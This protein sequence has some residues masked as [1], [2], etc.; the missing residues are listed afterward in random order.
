MGFCL[1]L[2][3]LTAKGRDKPIGLRLRQNYKLAEIWRELGKFKFSIQICSFD[4]CKIIMSFIILSSSCPRIPSSWLS[5]HQTVN[6]LLTM[7]RSSHQSASMED[8]SPSQIPLNMLVSSVAS[9]AMAP[10]FLLAS[11]PTGDQSFLSSPLTFQG[12]T[13]ATLQLVSELR[14]SI[15]LLSSSLA[16]LLSSS[17]PQMSLSSLVISSSTWSAS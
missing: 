10:T 13:E 8:S 12:V 14:D 9:T 3:T 1:H 2:L 5:P 7:Q 17:P 15:A 11:L 6:N 16:W 4:I